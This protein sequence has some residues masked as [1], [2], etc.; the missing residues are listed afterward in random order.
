M[1]N[2]MTIPDSN[3]LG[4]HSAGYENAFLEGKRL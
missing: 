2:E 3:I 4:K 1:A